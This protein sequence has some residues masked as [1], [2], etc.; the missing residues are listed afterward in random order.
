MKITVFILA[1]VLLIGCKSNNYTQV[2]INKLCEPVFVSESPDGVT[3][4][5]V[6]N[7]CPRVGVYDIYFSSKG[8][9][10]RRQVGKGSVPQVVPSE[11]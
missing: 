1:L 7:R 2:D 4:W 3:L 11:P 5:K 9:D 6:D 10:Y 8:A